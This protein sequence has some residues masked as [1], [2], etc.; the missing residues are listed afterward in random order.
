MIKLNPND[1]VACTNLGLCF[2]QSKEVGTST[3]KAYKRRS[4]SIPND[5][6]I[7][8]ALG[9]VYETKGRMDLAGKGIALPRKPIRISPAT[10]HSAGC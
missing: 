3:A 7:H 4:G 2:W 9:G 8:F 1:A 6:K 10:P 5:A